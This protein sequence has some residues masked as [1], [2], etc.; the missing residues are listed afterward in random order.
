MVHKEKQS[1]EVGKIPVELRPNFTVL[2][3]Y[4]EMAGVSTEDL[5][6]Y[7][8]KIIRIKNMIVVVTDSKEDVSELGAS[9]LRNQI[10]S[11]P[12]TRLILPTGRTPMGTYRRLVEM[13]QQGEISFRD[14]VAQN[15][16]EYEISREN[17]E[18]V[19]RP[20]ERID[21]DNHVWRANKDISDEVISRIPWSYHAFMDD[22]LYGT[23]ENPKIDIKR[24]NI[25]VPNG[26]TKRLEEHCAETEARV[27]QGVDIAVL[28]IGQMEVDELPADDIKFDA[29]GHIG[30]N[31]P[32]SARSSLTRRVRLREKTRRDNADLFLEDNERVG[33]DGRFYR[34]GKDIT[35]EVM[36]RV[37]THA[38]T[39]GVSTI[40][41][42][43]ERIMLLVYG[44]NKAPA[45]RF[46]L[47]EKPS[48]RGSASYI[49]EHDRVLVIV[50]KE[51]AALLKTPAS[52]EKSS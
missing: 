21:K 24:E 1:E 41:D 33:K 3:R 35:D 42:N 15:L 48:E 6:R 49:Q 30:F 40:I 8:S 31:E 27:R 46:S 39:L 26:A 14:V 23:S 38:V 11:K 12:D 22:N 20:G 25:H 34:S 16:D 51:A 44:K 32:G 37:P 19:L 50:D 45:L 2:N 4:A 18:A 43:S 13:Y 10:K 52:W 9:V 29:F 7:A 47:E 36:T 17:L 5:Y 28:G